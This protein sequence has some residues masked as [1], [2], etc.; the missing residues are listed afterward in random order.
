M[1]T[2]VNT[3]GD[4]VNLLFGR[5]TGQSTGTGLTIFQNTV[6]VIGSLKQNST[7]FNCGYY[8]APSC[9]TSV[10]YNFVTDYAIW[11]LYGI[12]FRK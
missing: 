6:T 4:N 10:S 12:I 7:G 11:C 1:Q 8:T 3:L 9:S 5:T 2:S